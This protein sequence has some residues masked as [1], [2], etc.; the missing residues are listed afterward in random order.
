MVGHLPQE[1]DTE[2][3]QTQILHGTCFCASWADT[4][5]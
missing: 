4:V 3:P 1:T 5:W 2:L